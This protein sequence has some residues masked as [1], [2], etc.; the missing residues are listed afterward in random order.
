LTLACFSTSE[1]RKNLPRKIYAHTCNTEYQHQTKYQLKYQQP[2]NNNRIK[3]EEEE[4]EE[5]EEKKV[6]TK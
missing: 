4:E 5:E 6:V 2:M 1:N 3:L